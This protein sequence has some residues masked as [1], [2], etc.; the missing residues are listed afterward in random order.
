L[1]TAK[2]D[3]TKIEFGYSFHVKYWGLGLATEMAKAMIDFSFNQMNFPE[4]VAVTH[5]ENTAS[6]N[7][8]L[9]AG[10]QR[11]GEVFWHGETLPYFFIRK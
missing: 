8:L 6:Q 9:K 2:E 3:P 11:D 4:I 5:P 7:V 1:R 10:M